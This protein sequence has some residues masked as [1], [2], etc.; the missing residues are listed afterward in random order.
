MY[1]YNKITNKPERI[2]PVHIEN[3][4]YKYSKNI[5]VY[6]QRNTMERNTEEIFE[7]NNKFKFEQLILSPPTSILGGNYFIKFN[8]NGNPLKF[9]KPIKHIKQSN[10]KNL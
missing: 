3:A 6:Q 1:F 2:E 7:P 9:I 4:L 8:V 10:G 5:R